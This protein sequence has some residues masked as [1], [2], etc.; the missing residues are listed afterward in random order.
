MKNILTILLI[1]AAS[2]SQA[3]NCRKDTITKYSIGTNS[4]KTPYYLI[5]NEFNSSNYTIKATE[6]NRVNSAWVN[7]KEVSYTYNNS[8]KQTLIIDKRWVNN[9]W[10]NYSKSEFIFN[11]SN[12]PL[13][14][15][16]YNWNNSNN[17]WMPG[18]SVV[19]TYD[20]NGNETSTTY[21]NG[22]LTAW[23]NNTKSEM[24]Y[25]VNNNKITNTN[26]IWD[27]T[28]MVWVK[29]NQQ[30]MTYTASKKL[31][32][33]ERRNWNTGTS[34]FYPQFKENY[35]YNSSDL[36]TEILYQNWTGSKWEGASKV[37]NTYQNNNLTRSVNLAYA[38]PVLGF[39]SQSAVIY[40]YNSDNTVSEKI[41][42]SFVNDI[43]KN[44]SKT[45]YSYN[46]NKLIIKSE[47]LNWNANTSM[48]AINNFTNYT[49]NS[50]NKKTLEESFS[51]SS[52]Y[53]T[54]LPVDKKTYEF[55]AN[56]LEIAFESSNNF[57]PT[58]ARYQTVIREEYACTNVATN[59]IKPT[60]V[61]T[62]HIYPNP[63]AD[64][65]N[66]KIYKKTTV[67][68]YNNM[69]ALVYKNNADNE[70]L[71]IDLSNLANGMYYVQLSDELGTNIQK[72]NVLK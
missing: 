58:Q 3:Q 24:E 46:S 13:E 8:N 61:N 57:S 38:G 1:F 55:D 29:Q 40:L 63:A 48:Y 70:I 2:Y 51:Y 49:F 19:K 32:T 60:T 31:E 52:T 9:V 16:T 72:L 18:Q 37:A 50:A 71:V 4:I 42:N 44:S 28:N 5:I 22:Y 23:V 66:I 39:K 21:K 7:F 45:V 41:N 12:K 68:V 10:E 69:G 35:T 6:F 15:N 17:T 59:H 43:E 54:V 34:S 14:S 56:G 62:N 53:M 20:A 36:E 33:L 11:S 67:A 30:A 25:D 27:N 47:F 65:V 26:F 64:K